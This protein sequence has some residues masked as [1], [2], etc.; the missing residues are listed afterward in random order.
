MTVPVL[1]TARCEVHPAH[2]APKVGHRDGADRYQ[3]QL[4]VDK[5]NIKA[6]QLAF[7]GSVACAHIKKKYQAPSPGG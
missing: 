6:I 2:P 3:C 5:A 4:C 7:P 1:T